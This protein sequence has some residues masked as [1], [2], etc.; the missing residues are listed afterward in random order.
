M[1]GE[2]NDQDTNNNH[3]PR[4]TMLRKAIYEAKLFGARRGFW[5]HATAARLLFKDDIP[6]LTRLGLHETQHTALYAWTQQAKHFYVKALKDDKVLQKLNQYH[7]P[8]EELETRL[9]KLNELE[10]NKFWKKQTDKEWAR[11]EYRMME[12]MEKL[13]DFMEGFEAAS[14]EAFKDE[15][16]HLVT[17]GMEKS[18]EDAI[19]RR[20]L[21]ERRKWKNKEREKQVEEILKKNK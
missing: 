13:V 15:P 7:I 18:V 5:V 10:K 19:E 9:Q 8:E 14:R 12:S 21:D 1:M 16:Q 11:G 3:I 20:K 6:T 17:L 4:D 2:N